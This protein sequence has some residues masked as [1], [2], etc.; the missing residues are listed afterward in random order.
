MPL[1]SDIQTAIDLSILEG[2]Y[3]ERSLFSLF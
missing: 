2:H 1:V 3:G